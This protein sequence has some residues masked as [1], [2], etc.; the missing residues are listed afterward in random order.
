M[1]LVAVLPATASAGM[2]MFLLTASRFFRSRRPA[3]QSIATV[4]LAYVIFSSLLVAGMSG[5]AYVKEN[6]LDVSVRPVDWRRGADLAFMLALFA[7]A[8][9]ALPAFLIEYLVI[10]FVRKRWSPA[11]ARGVSP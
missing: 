9:S 8:V 3:A 11:L 2:S 6:F 4:F 5:Y 1:F 7:F 10:R